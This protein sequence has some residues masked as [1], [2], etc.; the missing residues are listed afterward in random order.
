MKLPCTPSC[1]QKVSG[2]KRRGLSR[3]FVDLCFRRFWCESAERVDAGK[4]RLPAQ[5]F[6]FVLSSRLVSRNSFFIVPLLGMGMHACAPIKALA[7]REFG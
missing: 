1:G 7:I 4:E 2:C 6:Y 3:S 5:P